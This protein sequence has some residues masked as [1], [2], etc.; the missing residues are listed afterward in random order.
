MHLPNTDSLEVRL[1]FRGA[2]LQVLHINQ[3]KALFIGDE[4]GCDFFVPNLP[5]TQI[6]T[7][8]E[9]G[10]SRVLPLG[11]AL[12]LELQCVARVEPPKQKTKLDRSLL[13]YVGS[14]FL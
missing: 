8:T 3:N 7:S 10:S 4:E 13:A 12:S 9:P 2:K 5:K 6:V 1:L 11:E 14:S